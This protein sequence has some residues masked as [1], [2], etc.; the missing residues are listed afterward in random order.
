MVSRTVHA[1]VDSDGRQVADVTVDH[2]Y[3]PSAIVALAG[4]SLR[5]VFRRTD[6]D[7]CTERV[8]FSAPRLERRLALF[9]TTIVELPAQPAGTVRFTCRM[10]RY[11]G[12]VEFVE[13]SKPSLARRVA[14]R[15][16]RHRT[17]FGTGL[18]GSISALLFVALGAMLV[19]DPPVA[20]AAADDALIAD[21]LVAF[22]ASGWT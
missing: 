9:G 18:L 5:L 11:R 21:C 2:G 19:P 22:R 20:T 1:R 15:A 13:D 10:G 14:G 16:F 3:H 4:R 6:P 7:I 12:R 8:L 17:P